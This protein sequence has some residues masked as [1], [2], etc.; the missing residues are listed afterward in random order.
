ML[1]TLDAIIH[2]LTNKQ[3]CLLLHCRYETNQT[4]LFINNSI[5]LNYS[6]ALSQFYF[7]VKEIEIVK[8]SFLL[9]SAQDIHYGPVTISTEEANFHEQIGN[10]LSISTKYDVSTF[11]S[12]L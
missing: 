12:Y 10:E 6:I 8:M 7:K 3:V 4:H 11:I 9:M 5:E 1:R 2:H